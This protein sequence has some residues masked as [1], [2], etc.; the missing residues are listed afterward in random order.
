MRIN[1][2]GFTIIEMLIV[3]AIIGTIAAIA[4][5]GIMRAREAKKGIGQGPPDVGRFER[6]SMTGDLAS[7][8]DSATFVMVIRDKADD[9]CAA[10]VIR[11]GDIVPWPHEITCGAEKAPA[12]RHNGGGQ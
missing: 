12:L 6:V 4:V 1:Q 5:P 9:K 2:K 7:A 11:G 10:F 8:D 3:G